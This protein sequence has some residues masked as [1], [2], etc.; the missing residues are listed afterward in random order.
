M[1]I[2]YNLYDQK[3]CYIDVR[4]PREFRDGSIPGAFNLPL[5]TD[6]AHE[7]VGTCYKQKGEAQAKKLAMGYVAA[8]L[9]EIYEAFLEIENQAAEAGK[10]MVMYCARGGMRSKSLQG[11]LSNIGHS[12]LRLEGGYKAY[13]HTVLEALE[14]ECSEANFIV[15]HG[16]TGVGKTEILKGLVTMGHPV[17]DIEGLCEHRG[18]ML[19][20]IGKPEQPS[21]KNF[22]HLL[23]TALLSS[24][25]TPIF[26]EAESKRLGRN[27]LPDS[28]IEAMKRGKHL[29]ITADLSFR[30]DIL[31]GEYTP[32][33]ETVN[34]LISVLD[35][36]RKPMGHKVVDS[37]QEAMREGNL[38]HVA[39]VLMIQYYDPK[40]KHASKD[41]VMDES[42]HVT[43]IADTVFE[44][45]QWRKANMAGVE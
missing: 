33:P 9:S 43:N 10:A 18:S 32:T 35:N 12:V 44:L 8:R 7:A 29:N 19:G 26:V 14:K 25:K 21:Q 11:L 3:V 22:E 38:G 39:E 42:Y 40:Y 23:L 41:I 20:R 24:G 2:S 27:T 30:K 6:E 34:E 28:F 17:I 15:L 5:F 37:L 31:I 4:S 13:R 16:A 45:D 1:T 36:F